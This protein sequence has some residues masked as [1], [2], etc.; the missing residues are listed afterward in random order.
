MYSILDISSNIR[1]NSVA[2]NSLLVAETSME[3]S[4]LVIFE[5]FV[6]TFAWC[7]CK[8]GLLNLWGADVQWRM[9][10]ELYERLIYIYSALQGS[11]VWKRE[12]AE[13]LHFGMYIHLLRANKCLYHML[14]HIALIWYFIS[15]YK[16]VKASPVLDSTSRDICEKWENSI[17]HWNCSST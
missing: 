10:L 16:V 15:V 7:V 6:R 5:V 2:S 8:F 13:C 4:S 1:H 9:S 14:E 12:F 11:F 3:N 17:W